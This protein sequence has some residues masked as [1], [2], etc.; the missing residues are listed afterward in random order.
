MRLLARLLPKITKLR[1]ETVFKAIPEC[2]E[3]A[4]CEI[5]NGRDFTACPQ[6]RLFDRLYGDRPVR[7]RHDHDVD[8]LIFSHDRA[9]AA[10]PANVRHEVL[11]AGRPE[12]N[13]RAVRR[14][15]AHRRLGLL[16][17]AI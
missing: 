2:P 8:R 17:R 16:D 7:L 4:G 3:A 15:D 5:P 13:E 12:R 9:P 1:M 11:A 6:G 14:D 10:A